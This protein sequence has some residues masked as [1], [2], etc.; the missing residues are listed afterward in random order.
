VPINYSYQTTAYSESADAST[1][2][3]ATDWRTATLSMQTFGDAI[4]FHAVG[5]ERW[6]LVGEELFPVPE[7]TNEQEQ[8]RRSAEYR[9][10]KRH[11]NL[12]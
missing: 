7:E 8:R 9:D 10:S 12:Q 2:T 4:E 5:T 3:T 11:N 1:W 6:A